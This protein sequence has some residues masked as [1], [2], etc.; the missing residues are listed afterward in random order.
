MGKKRKKKQ[1]RIVEYGRRE[2]VWETEVEVILKPTIVVDAKVIRILKA[3]ERKVVGTE[4]IV[5]F[6]GKWE[7]GKFYVS[8]EYYIPEQ[9][10]EH[11]HAKITGEVPPEYNVIVHKHPDGVLKFSSTD[12]EY[13]NRNYDASLL[14]VQ[15]RINDATVR[16]ITPERWFIIHADVEIGEEEENIEIEG[17]E[18]IRKKEYRYGYGYYPYGY[19][20]R[21]SIYDEEERPR[22]RWKEYEELM[23]YAG[24]LWKEEY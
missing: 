24:D 21:V 14:W 10:V 1:S 4:F 23:E 12:Y 15:G 2:T 6:K 20:Y 8:G 9:E 16:I 3:I 17:I 5:L 18:R 13:I 11:S 22:R 7:R 19:G